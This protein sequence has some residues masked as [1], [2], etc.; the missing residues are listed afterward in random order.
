VTSELTVLTVTAASIGVGHTLLGPDH[1]LPFVVL[2]R[3]RGW[4]KAKTVL[5]TV[6]C[7]I[8][9][10]GSS[11][12]LGMAGIALG[13]AVARLE[14]IES[15]RGDIAAWLL[16]AF[17]LVYMVWGIRHAARHRAHSHLHAHVDGERHD[18][19]HDNE[20]AHLHPHDQA[21]Q[22]RPDPWC[23]SR[24]SCSDRAAPVDPDVPGGGERHRRR[25]WSPG[26]SASR[27]S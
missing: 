18:H 7:G 5:I 20:R 16:I 12:V 11:I 8:G 25:R 19:L 15:V 27:P 17:G 26:C 4:S 23:C 6:L 13:V 9:H 10:V 22:R 21:A 3:A 1:Y 24:S 2:A 14:G